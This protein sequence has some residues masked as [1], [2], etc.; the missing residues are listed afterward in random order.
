MDLKKIKKLKNFV[1][2]FTF[3]VY[4]FNSL[5]VYLFLQLRPHESYVLAHYEIVRENI[6]LPLVIISH[7]IIN[8]VGLIYISF[9]NIVPPFIF[10]QASLI[11][12]S[13]KINI[14]ECFDEMCTNNKLSQGLSLF[15]I[16]MHKIYLRYEIL[17]KL[18]K[19]ANR[20]LGVL[21]LVNHATLIFIMCASIYSIL[22]QLKLSGI[23]AAIYFGAFLNFT[24]L[25]LVGHLLAAQLNSASSKLRFTL[26][27][28]MAQH[29]IHLTKKDL[30][31]ASSFLAH[32]QE[33]HLAACPLNLYS[34]TT[35]K[36][37][38]LLSLIISYVIVLLQS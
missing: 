19:R 29:S 8:F 22:Y 5:G 7:V 32:L 21:M 26:S 11:L 1:S 36:L 2:F 14:E 27:S 18:V 37:L 12:R 3:I 6:G 38:T 34:V 33:D 23:D 30:R 15:Q 28:L 4:I 24:Y 9:A 31:V 20:L 25:V 10:Y 17:S 13:L 16:R 35:S